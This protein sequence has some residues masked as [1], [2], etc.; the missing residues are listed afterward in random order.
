MPRRRDHRWYDV[1]TLGQLAVFAIFVVVASIWTA[2]FCAI[3]ALV[4][5]LREVHVGLGSMYGAILG[6]IGVLAVGVLPKRYLIAEVARD[7]RLKR[8]LMGN[9]EHSTDDWR[10]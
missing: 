7:S 2:T 10:D 6:P 5:K 1:A 4:A 3:G 9:P 8:I